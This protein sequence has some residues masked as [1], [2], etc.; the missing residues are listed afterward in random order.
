MLITGIDDAGRGSVIGPLVI[1]GIAFNKSKL[2]HLKKLGVKDSKELSPKERERIY[3]ELLNLPCKISVV[4]LLPNAIDMHVT[5]KKKYRKL[6]YLEAKA[7]AEVIS[8][9]KAKL[10]YIDCPDINPKR[11]KREI[12]S[13]LEDDV[14]VRIVCCHKADKKFTIVSAASIIAKVERDY[15]I[16]RI[17]DKLG[18]FGSGYP[19]DPKTKS[20]IKRYIQEKENY[21]EQIRKSWKTIKKLSQLTLA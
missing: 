2:K 4:H 15:S 19:S 1:A 21:P 8:K 5:Q 20:F 16:Q 13:F 10:V 7:M 9:V 3:K 6:N 11:Y 17:K 18:D 12:E 14:N